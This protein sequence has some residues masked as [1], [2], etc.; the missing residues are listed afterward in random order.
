MNHSACVQHSMFVMSVNLSEAHVWG[1]VVRMLHPLHQTDYLFEGQAHE[2]QS[3]CIL[4]D[5]KMQTWSTA[6]DFFFLVVNI[7]TLEYKEIFMS[8]KVKVNI[9]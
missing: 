5:H 2:R 1:S 8:K 3:T 9:I 7:E 4:P 6:Y